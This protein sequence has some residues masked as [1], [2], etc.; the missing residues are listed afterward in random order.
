M[1]GPGHY[2]QDLDI[3][4]FNSPGQKIGNASRSMNVSTNPVGPGAYDQHSKIGTD[5]P[6]YSIGNKTM[7]K[8]RD[9]SPGPGAYEPLLN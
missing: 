5:G 4:R 7:Q 3:T 6:K 1:P 8:M 9:D 2:D